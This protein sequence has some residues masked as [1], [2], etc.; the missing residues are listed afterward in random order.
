MVDPNKMAAWAGGGGQGGKPG[1]EEEPDEAEM[2]AGS[3]EEEDHAEEEA[4]SDEG[5]LIAALEEFH[6]EAE[7]CCDELDAD[8]LGEEDLPPEEIQILQEGL[9]DLPDGLEQAIRQNA[10]GI[11]R[12]DAMRIAEHLYEEDLIS[13]PDRLGGWLYHAGSHL[14]DAAPA[15][16]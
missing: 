16:E 11:A 2:E 15:E 1:S 8:A 10:Q 12:E 13:D 9:A 3:D 5:A 14:A 7:A 6:E 4:K